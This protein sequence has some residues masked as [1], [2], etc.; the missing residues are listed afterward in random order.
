M[1]RPN[2]CTFGG[3]KEGDLYIERPADQELLAAL[4]RQEYAYV[5]SSRQTGKTSLMLRTIRK[6]RASGVRCVK[7]DLGMLGSE[8]GPDAWY[9]SLALEIAESLGLDEEFAESCFARWSRSTPV[10]R[11]IRFLREVVAQSEMPL[12]LFV[13]EIEGFLKLPMRMADEFLSAMRALYNDRDRE[14]IYRRLSF[15]LMGVCTPTELIRDERRTPFNVARGISLEDFRWDDVKDGFLSV[16]SEFPDAEQAL[17]RIFDWTNGHPYLTH[18][19]VQDWMQRAQDGEPTDAQHIDSI[20]R[21]QFLGGLGREH[22]NFL[23]VERRLS[24]GP[25]HR[26][27]QR[28]ALYVSIRRGQVIPARSRDPIQLELRLTGLIAERRNDGGE[29]VL[30]VR[31]RLLAELFDTTWAPKSDPA[32]LD[33]S[34]WMKE[35]T[36]RWH[37]FGRKDAFVLRGEELYEAQG[38][39]VEQPALDSFVHEF[40][41]ASE[42]VDSHERGIRLYSLLWTLLWS[43]FT[44]FLLVLLLP[45]YWQHHG[46]PF[47]ELIKTLYGLPFVLALPSGLLADRLRIRPDKMLLSG[48]GAIAAGT[49]TLL[50]DLH[51]PQHGLA[52]LAIALLLLGQVL[53]RPHVAVLV[54]IL[55]PRSDR[56]LDLTFLTYYFFVNLGALLGPLVGAAAF[57]QYGW[58]GLLA[59]AAAGSAFAFYALAASRR[60]FQAPNL[61]LRAEPP[62]PGDLGDQRRRTVLLLTATMLLFWTAFYALGNALHDQASGGIPSASKSALQTGNLLAQGLSSEAITPLFILIVTPLL[63]GITYLARRFQL[64]PPAPTKIAIGMLILSGLLFWLG[65]SAPGSTAPL[66]AFLVLTL[67]ELLVVPAS[68]SMTTAL[69]PS[70]ILAA[71]MGGYFLVMGIGAWCADFST[72]QS[73]PL[74]SVLAGLTMLS[75]VAFALRRRPWT[76]LF[77]RS[78]E[79]RDR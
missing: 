29:A 54:G 64:E 34:L 57:K 22:E 41:Q 31:N 39:A 48:L 76:A 20:V 6:L 77:P 13:D 79:K 23:E 58:T 71:M 27:R 67:A 1:T 60:V 51:V 24:L 9:Q 11:F 38:W 66:G 61:P 69:S 59:T 21:Q 43:S 14:P 45:D 5:L 40:L 26:A 46:Y 72:N 30:A 12:V 25:P 62:E 18:R 32:K 78:S 35:Q 33:P 2:L 37:D 3:L 44:N 4:Q 65:H 8:S 19:L 15:C 49:L 68:M 75:A 47:P 50:A 36:D 10:Q 63:A 16:L 73:A 53:Q 28:L 55:Y 56:R 52:F 7:L 17:R 74:L 42:R 70:N